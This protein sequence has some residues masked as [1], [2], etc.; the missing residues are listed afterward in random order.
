MFASGLP[1]M[2]LEEAM[3]HEPGKHAEEL[4]I[5][6]LSPFA[7]NSQ[8]RHDVVTC[9]ARIGLSGSFQVLRKRMWCTPT[10]SC[11]KHLAV[12][13]NARGRLHQVL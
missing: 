6:R 3:G 4:L 1:E 13:R 7:T 5:A 11:S 9:G 12:A 10:A 2:E 8:F